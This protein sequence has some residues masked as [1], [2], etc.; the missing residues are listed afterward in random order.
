MKYTRNKVKIIFSC[1]VVIVIGVI[2][3]LIANSILGTAVKQR[4]ATSMALSFL[5]DIKG[6]QDTYFKEIKQ[7][8]D[9]GCYGSFSEL[10]SRMIGVL[11]SHAVIGESSL[12]FLEYEYYI[13]TPTNERRQYT[14]YYVLCRP[15]DLEKTQ[16]Y[17]GVINKDGSKWM[18]WTGLYT[19]KI[20]GYEFIDLTINFLPEPFVYRFIRNKSPHR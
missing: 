8:T 6:I 11:P 14:Q 5:S 18:I 20:S 16:P 4:T 13:F 17:D 15:V 7:K 19:N 9:A 12:I 3:Y 10:K 2:C 1:S